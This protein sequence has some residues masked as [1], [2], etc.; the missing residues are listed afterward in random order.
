M[1]RD[2]LRMLFPKGNILNAYVPNN[3]METPLVTINDDKSKSHPPI[4]N[5]VDVPL[6]LRF[7]MNGHLMHPKYCMLRPQPKDYDKDGV[8][9]PKPLDHEE[10]GIIQP[11][12]SFTL[13]MLGRQYNGVTSGQ[14][15]MR[16]ETLIVVDED[17]NQVEDGEGYYNNKLVY[18]E[19]L[20]CWDFTLLRI[21]HAGINGNGYGYDGH[22]QKGGIRATHWGITRRQIGELLVDVNLLPSVECKP[23]DVV[24]NDD[25][26][27]RDFVEKVI[28]P[29][30]Y[31]KGTNMGYSLLVNEKKPL[32]VQVM[33]SHTWDEGIL[34]FYFALQTV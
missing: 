5:V 21:G 34:E 9:K 16:I 23:S 3:N 31:H 18:E 33:V 15:I 17:E 32:Q 30:T 6:Q 22:P 7:M 8:L 20:R 2:V 4:K 28:K 12:E 11:G 10:H 29:R 24:S 27:V 14:F 26:S 19:Y 25:I 1:I 13:K